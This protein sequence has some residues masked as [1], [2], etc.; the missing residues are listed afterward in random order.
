MVLSHPLPPTPNK[1][2]SITSTPT[3]F[4]IFC[5]SPSL[6]HSLLKCWTPLMTQ[7]CRYYNKSRNK[8]IGGPSMKKQGQQKQ[9]CIYSA[10]TRPSSFCCSFHKRLHCFLPHRD[11][12][13]ILAKPSQ[14]AH[15]Q[16]DK[17]FHE[18]SRRGGRSHEA[19]LPV[20]IRPSSH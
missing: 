13:T 10:I 3:S 18:D 8:T 9:T 7:Q 2:T 14:N 6:T 4:S 17:L 19:S 11:G 15:N 5:P 12:G 1:K 20:L 16:H